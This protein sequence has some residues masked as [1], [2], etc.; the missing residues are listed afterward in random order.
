MIVS[1]C[2]SCE[3]NVFCVVISGIR[4]LVLYN[5]RF[6]SH[7][8]IYVPFRVVR[9]FSLS[10]RIPY[11]TGSVAVQIES[12]SA[13]T[14]LHFACHPPQRC[15]VLVMS[16][17]EGCLCHGN[18]RRIMEFVYVPRA[19]TRS[20]ESDRVSPPETMS[21]HLRQFI[22]RRIPIEVMGGANTLPRSVK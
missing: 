7:A 1:Q 12:L 8:C 19:F 9:I 21:P 20:P 5:S 11:I 18:S 10:I 15:S 2:F 3:Q 16:H 4:T 6:I 17:I 22:V 14:R 13:L